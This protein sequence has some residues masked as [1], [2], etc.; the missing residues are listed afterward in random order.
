MSTNTIGIIVGSTRPE[1]KSIE[2][3]E[4]FQKKAGWFD[5]LE[6]EYKIIDLKDYPLPFFGEDDIN[7]AIEPFE[8]AIRECDGFIFITPEYNHSISGVLKNAL[9]FA[10]A[11]WDK[12]PAG[13]VSYGFG[14]NGA[15]AAEHLRGIMAALGMVDV[16]THMLI[17]L[18]DDVQNNRMCFRDLHDKTMGQMLLD[19]KYWLNLKG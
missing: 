5:G 7:N 8:Q 3:A 2:T 14:A 11:D 17:S 4:W 19:I 1:R 9:D 16:K 15:R 12:K 13:I 10:Y 18:F 6:A